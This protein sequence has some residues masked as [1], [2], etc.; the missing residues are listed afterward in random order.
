MTKTTKRAVK[1][2]VKLPKDLGK[3][4]DPETGELVNFS[5]PDSE[6]TVEQVKDWSRFKPQVQI[7]EQM[8]LTNKI[9]LVLTIVNIAIL[10]ILVIKN[11]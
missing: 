2:T 3:V 11:I 7:V 8:S 5:E 9:T 1:K 4:R 10:I 6:A